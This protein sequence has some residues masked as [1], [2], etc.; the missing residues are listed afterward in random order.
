MAPPPKFTKKYRTYLKKQKLR[1]RHVR[2]KVRKAK[3]I[4]KLAPFAKAIVKKCQVA[5]KKVQELRV[6]KDATEAELQ[7]LEEELQEQKHDFQT[8]FEN[9]RKGLQRGAHR[10]E[11][12]L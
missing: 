2:Q 8:Q 4:K 6:L 9:Q 11:A 5:E 12:L 1:K 10:A 3:L 7:A